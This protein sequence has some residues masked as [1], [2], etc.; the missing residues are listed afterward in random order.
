MSNLAAL[1]SKYLKAKEAYYNKTPLMSDAK[2]DQLEDYLRG[3]D[4]DWPEL[5]KT[6]ALPQ[7]KTEVALLK[8]MPSLNKAYPEA[9]DKWLAKNPS[10]D[11]LVT[12][13]LDGSSLQVVYDKGRLTQVVTRGNGVLG[14]DIT[15]L[16]RHLSVPQSINRKA[17]TIFRCEAVITRARFE[18]HWAKEFDTARNLVA[19]LLNRKKPHPALDHVDIVVLGC[20]GQSLKDGL[21]CAANAGLIAVA[22]TGITASR[23]TAEGLTELLSLRKE[24]SLYEMDGLVVVP[25]SFVLDYRDADKPKNAVAFKVNAEEDTVEAKVTGVVWQVSGHGRIIPKIEIQPTTIGGV[26]VTYCAAHNAQ[27]MEERGIG[28]GAVVKLVRSGG[29]IPKIVGVVK[30]GVHQPPDI[31]HKKRGVHYMVHNANVATS[32]LIEVDKLAKF[33]KTLGID[34]LA[35]KTL[36]RA[37]GALPTAGQYVFEWSVGNLRSVLVEEGVGEAMAEKIRKEFDRVLSQPIPVAKMMVASGCFGVGIGQRKLAAIEAAGVDMSLF[38]KKPNAPAT[39][40]LLADV[41][42][43]S[44]KTIALITEGLAVWASFRA[45]LKG[46]GVTLTA[47]SPVKVHKVGKLSG[48]KV[49]FTGYRDAEHEQAIEDAGGEVVPFSAKT[50]ILLVKEGGKASG[51]V[52]K[53]EAQGIKVV[54]FSELRL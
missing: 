47:S 41:P 31:K 3:M 43:F 28:P 4:P 46:C 10:G 54:H 9:I 23:A 20:Y 38:L 48:V 24:K 25:Y 15:F 37:H 39:E 21:R 32:R 35:D 50:N 18:K 6:G 11:Y 52:A 49:S 19:G 12:D 1:K 27:W 42:G 29:V 17:L 13:K 14:G 40:K 16:A 22:Q 26:K 7:K 34:F 33:V 2:F 53:A 30:K 45:N 51:K 44:S 5:A 36:T 8:P